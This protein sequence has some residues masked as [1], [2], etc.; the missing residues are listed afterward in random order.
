MMRS[1]KDSGGSGRRSHRLAA[2]FVLLAASFGAGWPAV[3]SYGA[4]LDQ[5]A[6]IKATYLLNFAKLVTWPAGVEDPSRFHI[7]VHGDPYLWR[8][9]HRDLAGKRVGGKRVSVS[10]LSFEDALD[11]SPATRVL[12]VAGCDG[13]QLDR[14]V[15]AL[16]DR[17]ILLIGDGPGFC[18]QGGIIGLLR[19][20][21][22][23]RFEVNRDLELRS[24]L[25]INSRL[26]RMASRVIE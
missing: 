26:L 11:P 13:D 8:A 25:S 17:P 7:S 20:E 6:R 9:C 24:G 16:S 22:G 12:Y 4:S 21:E 19:G 3:A 5:E 10:T 23:I 1:V 15:E 2:A 18:D 14:L